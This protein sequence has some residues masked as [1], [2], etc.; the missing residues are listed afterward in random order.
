MAKEK[1]KRKKTSKTWKNYKIQ[2]D[3]LTKD[4]TCPKCGSHVFLGKHKDRLYCG[5]CHYVEVLK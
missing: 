1:T 4:K 3:K 5:N 2:G